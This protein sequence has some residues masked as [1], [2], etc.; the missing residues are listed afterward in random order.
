MSLQKK[1]LQ[2]HITDTI[3]ALTAAKNA[4]KKFNSPTL[5]ALA[6]ARERS[7]AILQAA[8]KRTK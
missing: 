4:A 5:R 3:Q 1:Q 6:E 7:L 8:E 2:Y